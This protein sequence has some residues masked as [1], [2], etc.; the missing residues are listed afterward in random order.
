MLTRL[1]LL[2]LL[3]IAAIEPL[4][5]RA[6]S[7][8]STSGGQTR[9]GT[10]SA[11]SRTGLTLTGSWTASADPKTGAVTGTWTL[12]DAQ[13]RTVRR[14]AWS[15][16]KS[17]D[18]WDGAWRATVS[19]QKGEYSGTWTA[20]VDLKSNAAFANLF[21]LALKSVVSGG[22]RAGGQSGAWSIRA[23]R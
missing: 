8:Q 6:T 18:G 2:P 10:W 4:S 19:G 12:D 11:R 23:S 14:G 20:S 7:T 16:A 9:E 5:L 17:P 3:L 1:L 21:E 22:W 13:G 15:A